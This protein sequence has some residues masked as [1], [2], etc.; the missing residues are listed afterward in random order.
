MIE[1][2]I[3]KGAKVNASLGSLSPLTWAISANKP[4]MVKLLLSK[5]ADPLLRSSNDSLPIESLKNIREGAIAPLIKA[6]T[7]EQTAEEKQA[8]MGIPVPVWRSVLGKEPAKGGAAKEPK[9]TAFITINEKDPTAEMT[10]LLDRYFPGWKPGS[11]VKDARDDR[12]LRVGIQI[13][14]TT[15]KKIPKENE[16]LFY[17]YLRHHELPAYEFFFGK[18]S[19]PLSG[20]FSDGFVVL[21]G[22]TWMMAQEGGGVS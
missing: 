4:A 8:L 16:G 1:Q 21:L 3:K 14:K 18:S 20:S 11:A 13:T 19:G 5:G 17:D 12:P 15:T 9:E 22:G 10:P 6:L 7:R 2:L